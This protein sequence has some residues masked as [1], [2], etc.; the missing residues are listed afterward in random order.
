MLFL[1]AGSGKNLPSGEI[2]CSRSALFSVKGRLRHCLFLSSIA[3]LIALAG[4]AVAIQWSERWAM[5]ALRL[6]CGS[7]EKWE[8]RL[9][10]RDVTLER[11]GI[12]VTIDRAEVPKP[13]Y[14]LWEWAIRRPTHGGIHLGT[15]RVRGWR[16][17]GR[18]E[19]PNFQQLWRIF[20]LPF[21]R[22][23]Q[24]AIERLD[25]EDL[26]LFL[27]RVRIE[28]GIFSCDL[29]GEAEGVHL[30]LSLDLYSLRNVIRHLAKRSGSGWDALA[31]LQGTIALQKFPLAPLRPLLPSFLEPT[32]TI[33][34]R[35]SLD[36]GEP[37]GHLNFSD[38]LVHAANSPGAAHRV[39]LLLRR[40]LDGDATVSAHA[41]GDGGDGFWLA[42]SLGRWRQFSPNL[43]GS[44][45]DIVLL[46]RDGI[47]LRGDLDCTLT[48]ENGTVTL[49]GD[50]ILRRGMWLSEG[51]NGQCA[52]PPETVLARLPPWNLALRSDGEEFLRVRTSYLRG[53]LS[54]HL[55]VGG[56][57][58]RPEITGQVTLTRGSILFPFAQFDVAQGIFTFSAGSRM[59]EWHVHATSRLYGHDLRL[60]IAGSDFPPVLQFTATPFLTTGEIIA[61]LVTGRPPG[62]WSSGL[63]VGAIGAYLGTG[64][65]GGD[66]SNRMRMRIGEE[67]TEAGQGTVE[68]EY[69][70]DGPSSLLINY[71]RF[72]HYNVDYRRRIYAR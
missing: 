70:L 40:E 54:A 47:T 49:G 42:G 3:V 72:D 31:P 25:L 18:G 36:R 5:R 28:N 6:R 55:I 61:A 53:L 43:H 20:R 64:W 66:L 1:G 8:A 58:N 26:P 41:Y 11:G 27:E 10:L 22:F 35:L 59:P 65:L 39:D 50:L 56:M 46:Q 34:G 32:G 13:L 4:G 30:R 67:I 19:V 69:R 33:S 23:P 24:L 29:C 57:A 16:G 51:W 17:Q 38:L 60:N 37:V 63:P 48:A 45:T 52:A 44:G 68:V 12:T 14:A 21:F 2:S 15:V 9:S 71:D 7:V 62:E